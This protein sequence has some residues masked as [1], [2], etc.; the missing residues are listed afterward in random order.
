ML[1]DRS[2]ARAPLF[3]HALA[4]PL[5]SRNEPDAGALMKAQMAALTDFDLER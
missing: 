4:L 2:R 5:F 1:C 3:G